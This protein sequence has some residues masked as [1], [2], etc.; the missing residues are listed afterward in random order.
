MLDIICMYCPQDMHFMCMNGDRCCCE[1]KPKTL[2]LTSTAKEG[3]VSKKRDVGAPLKTE[4]FK[5]LLSTGRKR[6]AQL[7]AIQPGQVCAWAWKRNCGGGTNPIYGCSGRPAKHI[8]HGP[9]KSV[10]NNSPS[11]VSVICEFC[12]NLWHAKNDSSYAGERPSDGAAWLPTGEYLP[13]NAIEDATVE[14]I[15]VHE[16]MLGRPLDKEIY[17]KQLSKEA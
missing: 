5:D 3:K 6:A 14:E 13:L 8:H 2:N 10:L 11:N 9:D 1:D 12:H 15:L 4:D 16:S 7:Y 17:A